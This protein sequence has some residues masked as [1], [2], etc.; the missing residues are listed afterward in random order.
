MKVF[1][2]VSLGALLVSALSACASGRVLHS[3]AE[4]VEGPRVIA[5]DA[6]NAPWVMEIQSRLRAK[7][8]RVMRWGSTR[9]VT[10]S[11]D[12]GRV[13]QYN[14]A[15]A[16]YV[17][18]IDGA[19]PLDV[20]NRCFAGGYKFDYIT[21]DLVDARTNETILNVNGAG[22]SEN[23]P[24]LSGSIFG[25]IADAVDSVWSDEAR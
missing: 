1:L 8:F 7:G 6:P 22:Y 2:K 19:A 15:S 10:E 12:P 5:L 13:E 25:D 24:P 23:C 21:A 17:L 14:E 18:V 20:A 11:T 16:R 4:P 9:R 3:G